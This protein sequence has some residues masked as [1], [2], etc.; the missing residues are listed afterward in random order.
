MGNREGAAV[1]RQNAGKA[2]HVAVELLKKLPRGKSEEYAELL[3][4]VEEAIHLLDAA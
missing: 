3:T 1:S 4:E 2:Y